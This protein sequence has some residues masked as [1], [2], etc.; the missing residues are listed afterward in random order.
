MKRY[1]LIIMIVCALIAFGCYIC[2]IYKNK[3]NKMEEKANIDNDNFKMPDLVGEISEIEG[4]AITLKVISMN[5]PNDN[6]EKISNQKPQIL[7]ENNNNSIP[8]FKRQYTGELKKITIPEEIN[9]IK[10]ARG[11]GDV[12]V[13]ELKI[14]D[15]L[16]ITY[17][18]DKITIDEIKLN[19]QRKKPIEQK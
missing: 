4:R 5:K 2:Y 9:K 15:I 3:E 11:Q 10:N 14:G 17:K 7:S 16:S 12:K 13:S 8:T 19:I 1:A 18:E 6:G